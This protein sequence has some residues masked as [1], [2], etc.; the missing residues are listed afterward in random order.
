MA[1]YERVGYNIRHERKKRHM[2]QKDLAKK[3]KC[4]AAT[5][6]CIE[7]GSRRCSL[8]YIDKIAAA[9][10]MNGIDLIIKRDTQK[11]R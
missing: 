1:I 4:S 6:S 3:L 7:N 10:E 9:F 2:T 5:I 11:D 8:A